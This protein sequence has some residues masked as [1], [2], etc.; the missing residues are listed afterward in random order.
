MIMNAYGD[1]LAPLDA[2]DQLAET[3]LQFAD[4]GLHGCGL[5]FCNVVTV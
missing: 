2:A 4:I 1:R 5:F 3:G